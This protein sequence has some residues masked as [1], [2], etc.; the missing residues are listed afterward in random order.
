[1]GRLDKLSETQ[2][3]F[4]TYLIYILITI[5]TVVAGWNTVRISAMPE[6]YVQKERYL[7][8]QERIEKK[9]DRILDYIEKP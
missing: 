8:D 9:L 4:L 2:I 5:I 1:M 7:C 3:K 6:K